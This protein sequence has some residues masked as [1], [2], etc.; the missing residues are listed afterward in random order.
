MRTRYVI[1]SPRGNSCGIALVRSASGQSYAI[2]VIPKVWSEVRSFALQIDH[3]P[4]AG[5]APIHLVVPETSNLEIS[6]HSEDDLDCFVSAITNLK[7]RDDDPELAAREDG[8]AVV[9]LFEEVSASRLHLSQSRARSQGLPLSFVHDFWAGVE[10]IG[11]TNSV[12]APEWLSNEE[13]ALFGRELL[14]AIPPLEK[15][16]RELFVNEAEEAIRRRTPDFRTVSS[17]LPFIR[18]S[19]TTKGLR[20]VAIGKLT[21]LECAH[22]ELDHDHPWQQVVRLAARQVAIRDCNDGF[23][24][25]R[26][27]RCRRIDRQLQSVALRPVRELV[28]QT[29]GEYELGKNRHALRAS[30]LAVAVLRRDTPGGDLSSL[31]DGTAAVV[32]LR[33]STSRLFEVLLATSSGDKS[34]VRIVENPERVSLLSGQSPTKKPD[35]LLV[36]GSQ[37]VGHSAISSALAVLDAKYKNSI[38]SRMGNMEM[39]DQYQQFAYAAI[40]SKP[41]VFVFATRPTSEFEGSVWD[42]INVP[43]HEIKVSLAKFPFPG[44][45][46]PW[47]YQLAVSSQRLV[48]FLGEIS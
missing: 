27:T 2:S 31:P 39:T 20:N 12:Q 22:A 1:A 47:R 10:E 26:V 25:N 5:S 8:A 43:G 45:G 40:T 35:L 36:S 28:K 7:F 3:L 37:P 4:S 9:P 30:R 48:E 23:V 42:T 32:G 14:R 6:S 34:R 13:P 24:S 18:G 17:D 38:P 21:E 19:L 11:A 44:P 15:I 46:S 41:V 29:F 16:L 33:L